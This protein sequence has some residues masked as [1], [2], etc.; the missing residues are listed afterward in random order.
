MN[1]W[2]IIFGVFLLQQS[3]LMGAVLALI[4]AKGLNLWLV[5]GLYLVA[6]VLDIG[7]GFILGSFIQK[8]FK[9]AFK[10]KRWLKKRTDRFLNSSARKSFLL[11]A[12]I[13]DYPHLNSFLGSWLNIS[14]FSVFISTL[15]GSLIYYSILWAIVLGALR[16]TSNLYISIAVIVTVVVLLTFLSKKYLYK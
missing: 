4:K 3:A 14:F 6:T 9:T 2:F 8:K 10:L 7:L 12:G 16:L 5:H 13:I 1:F 15:I 11:L